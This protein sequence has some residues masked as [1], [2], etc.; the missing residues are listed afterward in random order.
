[1]RL[2]L[3]HGVTEAQRAQAAQLYWHAFGGK[4]GRVMGPEPRALSFIERVISP[5]HVI[6]G[7]DD[8]G[9]LLGVIG[10]RTPD[11]S[12]VGGT[13]G[14]LV[15]IYG[16]LGALWRSIALS[17]LAHDLAPGEVAVDGLAVA[18]AARGSGLGGALVEALCAEA[19]QRGYQV[20]RLD[21][22]GENLRAR[23]LYDRLGFA[24]A[25][26]VDSL[27]TEWIFGFRSRFTMQRRL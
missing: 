24:V 14:D 6:A 1:M 5:D 7:V 3:H 26:R 9:T 19:G 15:A 25:A 20:L 11:G 17:V 12:F 4:L 13:R 27:L 23:A 8:A 22:V 2:T 16:L 10:Y 18:E 21:V